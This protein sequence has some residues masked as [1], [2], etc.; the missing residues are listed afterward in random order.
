M[1][2][3]I[4]RYGDLLAMASNPTTNSQEVSNALDRI[5]RM[6]DKDPSIRIRYATFSA[7]HPTP[8][9]T[10]SASPDPFGDF[11]TSQLAAL[12]GDAR[13]A[14][15]SNIPQATATIVAAVEQLLGTAQVAIKQG[16]SEMDIDTTDVDLGGIAWAREITTAEQ[17]AGA[18][19]SLVRIDEDFGIVDGDVPQEGDL[20]QVYLQ[21]PIGML[22]QLAKKPRLAQEFLGQLVVD[23]LDGSDE[24][25]E[26]D[27]GEEA[28][29]GTR[30]TRRASA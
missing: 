10:A 7:K 28:P 11:L 14:V 1:P 17:V 6:E 23:L 24:D 20:A 30:F 18:Y 22:I 13:D 16:T 15:N 12:F 8:A 29:V 3:D 19:D 2:K 9:S 5:R 25:D 21:I 27:D 4:K 26:D